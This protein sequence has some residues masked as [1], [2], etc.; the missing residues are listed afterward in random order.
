MRRDRTKTMVFEGDLRHCQLQRRILLLSLSVRDCDRDGRG[1]RG[2]RGRAER[3]TGRCGGGAEVG[4]VPRERR[5][6][7]VVLGRCRRGHTRGVT[8]RRDTVGG[9]GTGIQR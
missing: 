7:L 6:V 2:G 4:N 5:G 3:S 8:E 1:G 9:V